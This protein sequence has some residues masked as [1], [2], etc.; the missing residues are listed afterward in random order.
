MT[1]KTLPL[2]PSSFRVSANSRAFSVRL[3]ISFCMSSPSTSRPSAQIDEVFFLFSLR[4][5]CQLGRDPGQA[6]ARERLDLL[7]S[8]MNLANGSVRARVDT[9]DTPEAGEVR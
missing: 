9:A 6:T 8:G 1:S 5:N 7:Q 2:D 3:A 4:S